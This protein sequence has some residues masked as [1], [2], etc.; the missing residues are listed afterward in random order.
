MQEGNTS[1]RKRESRSEK[2]SEEMQEE[3]A[4]SL[5]GNLQEA[6]M[7]HIEKELKVI[8]TNSMSKANQETSL[9]Q[10]IEVLRREVNNIKLTKLDMSECK[11]MGYAVSSLKDYIKEDNRAV[12]ELKG[13]MAELKN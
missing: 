5:K 4:S 13:K 11:I 2:S 7:T 8:R 10:Q 9:E 3:I 6:L 12:E 1:F